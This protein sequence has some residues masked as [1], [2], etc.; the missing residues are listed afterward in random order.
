VP[1]I[2]INNLDGRPNFFHLQN[3]A[4]IRFSR[5]LYP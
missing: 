1:T 5:L 3:I 4:C 2:F